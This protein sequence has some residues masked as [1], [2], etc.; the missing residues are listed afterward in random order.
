MEKSIIS[1]TS[2]PSFPAVVTEL[3]QYITKEGASAK[4]AEDII[5][6]DPALTAE[7]LRLANAP[8]YGKGRIN[9]IRHAVAFLGLKTLKYLAI[10]VAVT[11]VFS[12]MEILANQTGFDFIDFW[13]HSLRIA[14]ISQQ[15]AQ[16]ISY[17]DTEEA[18]IA[19]LLHDLGRL[20]LVRNYP[21]KY[22][23]VIESVVKEEV[24]SFESVE[25]EI[26]GIT[27]SEIG[28]KLLEYWN[29]PSAYI[30]V[31]RFHHQPFIEL[32]TTLTQIVHLAHNL[33]AL[34][35]LP[36]S[37]RPF[38]T[39]MILREVQTYWE[40]DQESLNEILKTAE[41]QVKAIAQH[42]GIS[43]E[44]TETKMKMPFSQQAEIL[45]KLLVFQNIWSDLK[46]FSLKG[47]F[48]QVSK[49][50][51]LAFGIRNMLYFLFDE[52]NSILKEVVIEVRKTPIIIKKGDLVWEAIR[53]KRIVSF[54]ELKNKGFLTIDSTFMA[55]DN[56]SPG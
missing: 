21:Q 27:H 1:E 20:I 39:E 43:F 42:L 30:D 24:K 9:N 56:K 31:A 32:K 37:N 5:K 10:T 2:F 17:Q 28:A 48:S 44:K 33:Q 11:G 12:K 41:C 16:Q 35:L 34:Y 7:I 52:K 18:F 14:A 40:L 53:Q 50:L 36:P 25:K 19:G 15:I 51:A 6:K 26:I 22:T 29:L 38:A 4:G 45:A 54:S 13:S 46:D 8:L 47:I 49:A 23:K 3:L 55:Q